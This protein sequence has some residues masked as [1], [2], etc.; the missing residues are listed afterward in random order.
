MTTNPQRVVLAMSGGVDSSAAAQLLLEQGFEVIGVFMRHGEEPQACDAPT[1]VRARGLPIVEVPASSKQG[2]CTARDAL[3]A[4]RVADRLGIPFYALN[5]REDFGRIINYFVDEY[6]AGRTPN[7]CVM[8]N[9]W[10]KFGKLFEYADSVE[11]RYVATGHYARLLG[12][13][14]RGWS[15]HRGRDQDKDQSYVLFGIARDH[16]SRM[17]LPV[18]DY[19]KCEIRQRAAAAGLRVADKPDS[20]E[21][22]FVERGRHAE[23]V[24]QR[25]GTKPAHGEIVTRDGQV[26]GYHTGVERFTIGQRKHLGVALG[27][28]YFVV[29]I[30]APQQRVVIGRRNELARRSLVANELNWL[31][32][33]PPTPFDALVQIRYNSTARPARIRPRS[34]RRIQVDFASPCEGVAPG[35][36]VVC[37]R[38]DQVLGGGWIESAEPV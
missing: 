24:R 16:L 35:Q 23:F 17:R 14:R 19:R 30:Q 11:A 32:D 25:R 20:Q 28:P 27:E 6:T 34:D 21:I 33:V 18:G 36:A 8:C 15:L 7:P 37:Y 31:V 9:N 13:E 4:R 1:D 29:E 22:C 3:D 12:D 10:L 2:C 26:V 38:D 5:L